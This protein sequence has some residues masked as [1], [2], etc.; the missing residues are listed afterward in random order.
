MNISTKK[1]TFGN[2]LFGCLRQVGCFIEV[3]AKSG[4]TV[5]APNTL[6]A[7]MD[8]RRQVCVTCNSKST[9]DEAIE[10]NN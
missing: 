8:V 9:S 2:I 5:Y 4:L 1:L 6:A 7:S 3:T 10:L